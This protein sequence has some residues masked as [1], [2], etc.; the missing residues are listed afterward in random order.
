MCLFFQ[1]SM[2]ES[3]FQLMLYFTLCS[4]AVLCSL[5]SCSQWNSIL[6][7]F[8]CSNNKFSQTKTMKWILRFHVIVGCKVWRVILNQIHRVQTCRCW[9]S[10]F[11]YHC[12]YLF[13]TETSASSV[14]ITRCKVVKLDRWRKPYTYVASV[15]GVASRHFNPVED[16]CLWI[17]FAGI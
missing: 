15:S 12:R 3:I 4:W 5:L 14:H 16:L 10:T 7:I 6:V 1:V 11:Q 8:I 17:E 2:N 13:I 9:F